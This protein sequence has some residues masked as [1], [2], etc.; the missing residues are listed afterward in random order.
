MCGREIFREECCE[1]KDLDWKIVWLDLGIELGWIDTRGLVIG[2]FE[3]WGG[4]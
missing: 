4:W 2:V 1:L 3:I